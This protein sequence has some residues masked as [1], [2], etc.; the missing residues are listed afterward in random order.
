MRWWVV[1]APVAAALGV[2]QLFRV[3]SG[4][5]VI[6][7]VWHSGPVASASMRHTLV[8]W[9]K[10]QLFIVVVTAV[11]VL[12]LRLADRN[13][14]LRNVRIISTLGRGIPRGV[15]IRAELLRLALILVVA[16]PVA[17]TFMRW[18][19]SATKVPIRQR[20][21]LV[22]QLF[23]VVQMVCMIGRVLLWIEIVARRVAPV[24]VLPIYQAALDLHSIGMLEAGL[25]RMAATSSVLLILILPCSAATLSG[26]LL[27]LSSRTLHGRC[28]ASPV[29]PVVWLPGHLPIELTWLL[30]PV[31]VAVIFATV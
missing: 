30:L 20:L 12:L 31:V 29:I 2:T 11:E 15:D 10:L 21:L 25:A 16:V 23:S 19:T 7:T 13:V 22:M 27:L 6:P 8:A 1:I 28:H 18:C 14:V 17:E 3:G 5:N 24:W 9:L 4:A 26:L